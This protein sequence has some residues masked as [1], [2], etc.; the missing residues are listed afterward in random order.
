MSGEHEIGVLIVLL[1][2]KI[3]QCTFSEVLV[4]VKSQTSTVCAKASP[5]LSITLSTLKSNDLLFI[6]N[7]KNLFEIWV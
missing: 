7:F 6:I 5:A 3:F 2:F 4:G 1:N